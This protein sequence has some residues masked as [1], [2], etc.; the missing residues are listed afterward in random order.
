MKEATHRAQYLLGSL[1][2]TPV[3]EEAG[4]FEVG[5][6][7]GRHS[8]SSSWDEF[9]SGLTGP[10]VTAGELCTAVSLTASSV[11]NKVQVNLWLY[12]QPYVLPIIN[13]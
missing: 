13:E 7:S 10:W 4:M 1:R 9:W 12:F 5:V 3:F 11:G 6:G 8:G 2:S